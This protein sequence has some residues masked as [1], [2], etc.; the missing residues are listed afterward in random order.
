MV[1]WC[2]QPE[3]KKISKEEQ[4]RHNEMNGIQE[5]IPFLRIQEPNN[6]TSGKRFKL[7]KKNCFLMTQNLAVEFLHTEKNART[8]L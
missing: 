5:E 2:F 1:D 7:Q 8:D 4:K 3:E 6:I